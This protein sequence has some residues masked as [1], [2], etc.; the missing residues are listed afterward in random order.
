MNENRLP[1]STGEGAYDDMRL[2]GWDE[3][4]AARDRFLAGLARDSA[5][6]PGDEEVSPRRPPA[7]GSTCP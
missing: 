2:G 5:G 1:A 7:S 6:E 4:A 3:Y